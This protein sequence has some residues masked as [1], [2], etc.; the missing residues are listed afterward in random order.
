MVKSQKT[1][2]NTIR[3]DFIMPK[4]FNVIIH[5]AEDVGGYWATC[6][7]Q[8]GGVNTIGDTIQEVESNM[9]EAMDLYLEDYPEIS[10]YSLNFEVSNA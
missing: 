7:M 3:S 8:D 9:F 6:R 5:P 10:E 1:A 2:Y 4:I